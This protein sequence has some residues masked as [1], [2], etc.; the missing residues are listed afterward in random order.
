MMFDLDVVEKLLLSIALGALI[1]MEREFYR[2]PA[3][4]RTHCLIALGSCL[5]TILSIKVDANRGDPARI[6]AQII[7]GVGFLGAGAILRDQGRVVG[8][9]TAAGIWMVASLGMAVGAGYFWIAAWTGL[10]SLIVL[11]LFDVVE[12]W[13]DLISDQR[14]YQMRLADVAGMKAVE[15]LM[16]EHGVRFRRRKQLRL[17]SGLIAV[18]AT[19]GRKPNQDAVVQR[20]LEHP[21]VQELTW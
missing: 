15:D 3:G 16:R 17:A 7:P 2:K 20:L 1:G 21:A 8:L 5:F 9:T 13:V 19:Q 11:R 4:F 12:D 18:W 10:I 14:T 6:A